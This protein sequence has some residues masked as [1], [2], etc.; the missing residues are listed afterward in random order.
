MAAVVHLQEILVIRSRR[1]R[2]Y[3][4][5]PDERFL[6][7]RG[8]RPRRLGARG[9]GEET[10]VFTG[11]DTLVPGCEKVVK[12]V[13][14]IEHMAD[15]AKFL[16]CMIRGTVDALLSNALLQFDGEGVEGKRWD[17]QIRIITQGTGSLLTHTS[18]L[19]R[20]NLKLSH[21]LQDKLRHVVVERGHSMGV[22]RGAYIV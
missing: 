13:N 16:V 4:G 8:P 5:R 21:L 12:Q 15:T 14:L 19:I 20:H 11:T 2:A 9:G 17:P 18:K 6:A 22:L 7:V 3:P 1:R 10:V